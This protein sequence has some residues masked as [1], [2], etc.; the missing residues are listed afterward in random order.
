MVEYFSRGKYVRMVMAA[1]QVE[2]G[3]IN[4]RYEGNIGD[5]RLNYCD[6]KRR[7][8]DGFWTNKVERV[9]L[10]ADSNEWALLRYVVGCC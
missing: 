10:L 9:R 1:V 3:K 5:V 6:G 7:E 4:E 2:K 8:W